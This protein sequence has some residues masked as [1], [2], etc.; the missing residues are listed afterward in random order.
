MGELP[1]SLENF[2]YLRLREAEEPLGSYSADNCELS[3]IYRIV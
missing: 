3:G 1:G 2:A